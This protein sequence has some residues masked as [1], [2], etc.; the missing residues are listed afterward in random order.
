V[1][2]STPEQHLEQHELSA[3]S[4]ALNRVQAVIEFDLHGI[5]LHANDNFLKALGYRFD[6]VRGQHQKMFC[7]AA[8]VDSLAYREFWEELGRGE[9]D[10]GEYLRMGRGARKVW[11]NASYNPMF[12]SDGKP[13]KVIKFATD[14][15]AAREQNAEYEGKVRAIDRPLAGIEFDQSG[16]VLF[17]YQNFLDTLG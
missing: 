7:E 16:N 11:I 8:Y 1:E 10:Q 13:F 5:V 14:I 6:E 3:V 17:A 15:T 9:F 4:A 12:D 2:H